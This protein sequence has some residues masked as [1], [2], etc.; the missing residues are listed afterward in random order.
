[1]EPALAVGKAP[2]APDRHT[3][4]IRST[5]DTL[6]IGAAT[7]G[8]RN[9]DDILEGRRLRSVTVMLARVAGWCR[10]LSRSKSHDHFTPGGYATLPLEPRRIPRLRPTGPSL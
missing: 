4:V 2:I 6:S 9:R 10:P 5:P 3:A 7:K 1:M 8:S